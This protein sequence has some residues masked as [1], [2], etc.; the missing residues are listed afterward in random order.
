M[1]LRIF[2]IEFRINK[3]KKYYSFGSLCVI[4]AKNEKEAVELFYN[5]EQNKFY[6][7]TKEQLKNMCM[8]VWY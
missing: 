2:N 3:L 8:E 4:Q 7:L 5:S 6:N 1:Y